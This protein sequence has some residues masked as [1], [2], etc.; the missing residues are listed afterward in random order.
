MSEVVNHHVE[1]LMPEIYT[2]YHSKVMRNAL[3]K[4]S[5]NLSKKDRLVFARHKSG[6]VFP[7]WISLKL[8]ETL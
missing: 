8:I 6:F 7:V 1:K 4:G 5:E 2:K 3:A